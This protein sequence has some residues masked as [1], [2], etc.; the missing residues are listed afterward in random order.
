MAL[1][2]IGF[3]GT[4]RGMTQKQ[5]DEL[6]NFLCQYKGGVFHH[7]DCVGADLEAHSIASKLGFKIVI[8]PPRN[9]EKRAFCEGV[10]LEGKNYLE[11]NRDIVEACDILVA[12]PKE[13]QEVL[14]S[15][16]WA[17]IRYAKKVGK[18]VKIIYP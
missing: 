2:I 4:R 15:G 18:L 5:K 14:R 6:Y 9:P 11:R 7:G 12:V 16:T 8:H 1:K 17:S 13:N 3:T 10:V